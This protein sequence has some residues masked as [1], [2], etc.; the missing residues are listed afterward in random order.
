MNPICICGA[1]PCLIEECDKKPNEGRKYYVCHIERVMKFNYYFSN[2]C[3]NR[4][5]NYGLACLIC[6]CFNNYYFL[7]GTRCMLPFSMVQ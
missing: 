1:G 5:N 2:F 4:D 3:F 7:V 6:S